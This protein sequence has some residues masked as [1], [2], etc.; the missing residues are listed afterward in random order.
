[1]KLVVNADDFGFSKS[2]NR[3]IINAFKIGIVSSTTIMM[4]MPSV[5]HAIKLYKENIGLGL[6]VHL[7]ITEGKPLE[8][9]LY[10]LIK[11]NGE[12][13]SI[14]DF[15]QLARTKQD[16]IYKELRAQI[17]RLISEGIN[18]THLDNHHFIHKFRNI[19]E[20]IYTLALEYNLPIRICDVNHR[21]E[22]R[23][24]GIKTVDFLIDGFYKEN[25]TKEKLEK[26]VMDFPEYAVVELMTH[27]GYMD[28]DTMNRTEYNLSREKEIQELKKFKE[29][30]ILNKLGIELI[31]YKYVKANSNSC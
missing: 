2:I 25:A 7:N 26:T 22:A 11:E 30:G 18:P 16:Q 27:P 4:N 3:G 6:G 21:N 23:K 17:N 1:M 29:G 12:F 24:L 10:S 15:K 8:G 5:N 14:H 31:S 9:K 13:H 28:E 20:T 19:R